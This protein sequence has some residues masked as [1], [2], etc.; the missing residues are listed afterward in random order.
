MQLAPS[1]ASLTPTSEAGS[2]ATSLLQVKSDCQ[3]GKSQLVGGVIPSRSELWERSQIQ[4]FISKM[5]FSHCISK[6]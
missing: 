6:M 2:T 1:E 5:Y 3:G 4:S